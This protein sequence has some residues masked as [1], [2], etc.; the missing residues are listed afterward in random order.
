MKRE[1]TPGKYQ[2]CPKCGSVLEPRWEQVE[3]LNGWIGEGD[4]SKCN[5]SSVYI[6][7]SKQFLR[8]ARKMVE[9]AN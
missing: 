7:G 6:S 4:C 2:Y 3:Y 8:E 5:Q 9:K 1:F